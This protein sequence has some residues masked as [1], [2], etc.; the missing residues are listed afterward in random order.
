MVVYGTKQVRSVLLDTD[1]VQIHHRAGLLLSNVQ[2]GYIWA[3]R[4]SIQSI[5]RCYLNLSES[6]FTMGIKPSIQTPFIC[7]N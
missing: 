3:H 1:F 4:Q 6:E 5:K 2:N 7:R